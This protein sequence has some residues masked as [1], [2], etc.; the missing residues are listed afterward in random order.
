MGDETGG[1][2]LAEAGG[3]VAPE[4]WVS[5]GAPSATA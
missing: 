5:A 1:T 4:R 2:G 3:G